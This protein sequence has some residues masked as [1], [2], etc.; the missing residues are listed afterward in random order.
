MKI[1]FNFMHRLIKG[2]KKL[3]LQKVFV[4][5]RKRIQPLKVALERYV[6]AYRKQIKKRDRKT[7]VVSAIVVIT[8]LVGSVYIITNRS[9]DAEFDGQMPVATDVVKRDAINIKTNFTGKIR[10]SE[11]VVLTAEVVGKIVSMKKD[12]S[13]VKKGEVILQL[14]STEAEGKYMVA[15]GKKNEE[16]MK[17][18]MTEL[19]VKEGYKTQNH[20]IEQK[21]RYQ[22]AQGHLME[23]KAYLN[24]HVI[25]APFN[26]VIGLQ[27]Q[28]IGATVNQHTKLVSITNLEN[29]Q[30]EFL[31]SE[32]ELRNL[33][34][35][36]RIKDAG[37]LVTLDGHLLPINAIFS[38]YETVIDAETNAIAVRATLQLEDGKT[39]SPGQIGKVVVNIGAKEDVLTVPESAIENEYGIVYVY[40][41][42]NGIAVKTPVKIGVKDGQKVEVV[43]GIEEGDVIITSGQHRLY[44]GQSV[45]SEDSNVD[46]A[47]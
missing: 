34:G 11:S 23:A 10:T 2:L 17:L 40:R 44:D 16:E 3:K 45:K 27:N 9:H 12:G 22:T 38:A 41:I 7:I 26:G 21:S 43:S 14:D 31:V 8:L 5:V 35:I 47:V 32:S 39:A 18:H 33:G 13:L 4:S 37:I 24:K 1:R 46:N 15:L 36:D 28:S 19:M 20:L 42:A 6:K 25:R 30:V 29:L